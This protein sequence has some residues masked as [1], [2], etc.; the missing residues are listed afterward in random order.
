MSPSVP[1]RSCQ[2]DEAVQSAGPDRCRHRRMDDLG[3]VGTRKTRDFI[4]GVKA[5]LSRGSCS[6]V[7]LPVSFARNAIYALYLGVTYP[8]QVFMSVRENSICK[9]AANPSMS[10]PH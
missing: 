7:F 2:R 1:G 10:S 9:A 6:Q 3:D 5:R 8:I 4:V